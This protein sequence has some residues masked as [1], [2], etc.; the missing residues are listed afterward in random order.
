MS[1]APK[2][3]GFFARGAAIRPDILRA[4][5]ARAALLMVES[6]DGR[7][8]PLS[9]LKKQAGRA[10]AGGVR[11]VWLWT[12]PGP[13]AVK[14]PEAAAFRATRYLRDLGCDGLILD[15]EKPFKGK[16]GA[17]QRMIA[18]SIDGLGEGHGLGLSSYP[19][20]RRHPTMPWG[21]MRVGGFFSPQLYETA[22]DVEAARDSIADARAWWSSVEGNPPWRKRLVIPT[23][24]TYDT[25]SPRVGAAQVVADLDRVC[26]DQAGAVDVTGALFWSEPQT[27][28]M[29]AQAIGEWARA[30]RW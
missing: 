15:M 5:R 16:P 26:R 20:T 11:E 27:S 19:R 2:G 18:A 25:P 22:G 17:A 12:F 8:Q 10:R 23:L 28:M 21:E 1:G 29:E 9:E 14:D 7:V 30:A 6:V 3:I 4:A 13:E 24:P